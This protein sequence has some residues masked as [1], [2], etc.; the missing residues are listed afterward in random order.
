MPTNLVLAHATIKITV[1]TII[2]LIIIRMP[3]RRQP[4]S[5]FEDVEA[6]TI[7]IKTLLHNFDGL[8]VNNTVTFSQ[9]L[10]WVDS[11]EDD[12]KTALAQIVGNKP[13]PVSVLRAA[14]LCQLVSRT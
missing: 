13:I 8:V 6:A 10:D 14:L 3:P 12:G 9:L 7:W 5:D 2:I 4:P 11:C 1:T